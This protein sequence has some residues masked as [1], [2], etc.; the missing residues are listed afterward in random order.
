MHSKLILLFFADFMRIAIPTANLTS[1]DWGETGVMENTVFLLDLPRRMDGKGSKD[2]LTNFGKELLFFLQKQGLQE[3]AIAGILNF[4][5]SSTNQLAFI[6]S[7]VGSHF[8]DD[9]RRTGLPGLSNAIRKLKLDTHDDVEFDLAVSSLGSLNYGF[10]RRIYDTV[11]GQDV[12]LN[13]DLLKSKQLPS[14]TV[15]AESPRNATETIKNN[16]R[17]Y[18][19]TQQTVQKSVGGTESAGTICLQKKY[20]DEPGFPKSLLRDYQ[21]TRKGL[22]SHNKLMFV[23]GKKDGAA[24]ERIAWAYVGSANLSESAWG[25]LVLTREK[26]APKLTCSN[27]ECGVL[28]PVASPSNIEGLNATFGGVIDVPFGPGEEYNGRIPWFYQGYHS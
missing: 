17:I 14:K 7:V 12:V 10:I 8:E 11:R 1:Y 23:R 22:L 3:E 24:G 13:Q 21:S 9:L 5:F 26:K 20:F 2:D 15:R 4:D 27:W 25:R 18:F 6:H 28:I 16:I 19:P